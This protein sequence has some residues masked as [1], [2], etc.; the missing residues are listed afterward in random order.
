MMSCNG[1]MYF[2]K[3]LLIAYECKHFKMI[4]LIRMNFQ[5]LKLSPLNNLK[6]P[7]FY[8]EKRYNL[9]NK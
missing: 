3:S 9:D 7:H 8:Y 6:K 4:T 2:W 1:K 5:F